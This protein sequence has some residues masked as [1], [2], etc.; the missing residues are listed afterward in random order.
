MVKM[1][2]YKLVVPYFVFLVIGFFF[3]PSAGRDD[4]HIT[5]W[6]AHSLSSFGEIVN[7]NGERIEQSSSL[8]HTVILA[9]FKYITDIDMVDIGAAVSIFFGLLTLYLTGKI[10]LLTKQDIFLPQIIAATSAPLLYWSFGALE[11]SMVSAII[12]LLLITTIKY[13]SRNTAKNYL[14]SSVS[15]FLYLLSRPEAFFVISLFLFIPASI[16]FMRR[17]VYYPLL[18]LLLTTI[19]MFMAITAFRYNYFGAFFPQ[20]VEAK[21]GASIVGKIY[22][23]LSYYYKSLIQY[24]LAIA[25]AIPIYLYMTTKAKEIVITMNLL[26]INSLVFT[27]ALFI[28]L[29]G[30]DWMEGARFIAPIIGP[31]AVVASLFYLPLIGKKRVILY[32]VVI[33]LMSLFYFVMNYSTGQPIAYYKTVVSKSEDFSFFE[34]SNRVHYRDIPVIIEIKAIVEKMVL[35]GIE[36]KIMSVQA[37]MVPYHIFQEYYKKAKFVDFFALS[38]R[39]FTECEIT[40]TLPRHSLGLGMSYKYYF[41]H[42]DALQETCGFVAPDIIFDLFEEN[43]DLV[44][45]AEVTG[46]SLVYLQTGK[47]SNNG[48]LKGGLVDGTQFI[49]VRSD[50][51]SQLGL[52][53][54]NN[55]IE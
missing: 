25:M 27:Y 8:L 17:E 40:N 35:Q 50:I 30:G 18:H 10:S 51:A 15:I 3:F 44:S 55:N 14:L 48:L 20:P 37:G 36:P 26:I 24:P 52:E 39:D 19:M 54:K 43:M 23:G 47:V 28:L 7:Y 11:T 13:V 22:S 4:V 29:S 41:S 33:N 45:D 53:T 2:N 6:A 31:M 38:T 16:F 42:I 12:L 49:A 1:K 21:I 32:G 34:T 9:G 46:Y 5:Y